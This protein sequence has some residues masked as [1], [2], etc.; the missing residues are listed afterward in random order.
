MRT[1]F[2][3]A[4]LREPG[5]AQSEKIL[6]ACV[7][8]GFCNA[9]CPTYLQTGNENDGP[10]GRIYLMRE[11]LQSAAP[12][13]ARTVAHIDGCLSCLGCATTCPSGVDYMRLVDHARAH[14]ETHFQRPLLEQLLRAAIG[15][16]LPHTGRFR[17]AMWLGKLSSP[18]ARYLPG[19]LGRMAA[20]TWKTAL[21]SCKALSGVYPAQ[22][23]RRRRVAL[24]NGCV[25]PVLAPEINI[26]AIRLLN[27]LGVEVVVPEQAGCCGALNYHLGQAASA[28]QF[29]RANVRAWAEAAGNGGLDAILITASGCGTQVKEYAHLLRDDDLYKEVAAHMAAI[30]QDIS[31]FLFALD[32]PASVQPQTQRIA[33]HA[34][35]SLQ[36]GQKQSGKVESLLQ[37]AGFEVLIPRDAHL[38]C[39]A[40]GSY[41]L[42]QPDMSARL[43]AA[44]TENLLALQPDII[45]TGNIGCQ[46]Q[47]AAGAKIP[48]LHWV[49]LLEQAQGREKNHLTNAL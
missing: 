4:Q 42:L 26:A 29:A 41:T 44:K 30:T 6:R 20:M 34:A 11:M 16:V 24:L 15:F 22:G 38:C 37:K 47:I 12:P 35:C 13:D 9:T 33:Y 2:S 48:V 8:C 32:L 14:I 46:V 39:G 49:Q 17:A 10:R 7:H 5:M 19:P 36:H 25:Q 23:A 45:A 43:A 27:Q 40:A 21:P 18:F 28:K 3:P 1:E 31:E